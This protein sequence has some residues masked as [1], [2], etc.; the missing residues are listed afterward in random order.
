MNKYFNSRVDGCMPVNMLQV[1]LAL[2][3][4]SHPGNVTETSGGLR[5]SQEHIY[6][7]TSLGS[8]YLER[9]FQPFSIS[10]SHKVMYENLGMHCSRWYTPK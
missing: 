10:G 8:G 4:L 6:K 9:P 1:A 3:R 7:G 2:V 5:R